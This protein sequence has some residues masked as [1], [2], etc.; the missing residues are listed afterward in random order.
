MKEKL[1]KY[2][3]EIIAGAIALLG[4]L[5]VIV[6]IVLGM[7]QPK[8]NVVAKVEKK[9]ESQVKVN[10]SRLKKED[11]KVGKKK[12]EVNKKEEPST[13]KE[14]DSKD[15]KKDNEKKDTKKEREENKT[16]VKENDSTSGNPST[17]ES[18]LENKQASENKTKAETKTAPQRQEPKQEAKHSHTWV[19][20]YKTVTIPAVTKTVHHDA[21]YET[22]YVV[23]QPARI[24]DITEGHII[25]VATGE[26]LGTELNDY[27]ESYLE[28]H[29]SSYTVRS[30][31]V[32]TRTIP[33]VGH[34]ETVLVQDAYDETVVV[35]PEK[36][37]QVADGEICSE[38]GARR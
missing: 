37:E 11:E 3:K 25:A 10:S 34:T 29:N 12:E 14:E 32:G 20:N 38:C 15:D 24:E 28:V 21:V 8:S 27:V 7:G 18:K 19:T 30:I 5:I 33:E 2:K 36:T 17:N 35:T 9:T 23:D 16:E 31:V 13:S 4:V 6:A 26:D 22:R 1:K